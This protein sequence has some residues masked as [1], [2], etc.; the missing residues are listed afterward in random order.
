[1]RV[2]FGAA[3]AQAI[4]QYRDEVGPFRSAEEP[5]EVKGLWAEYRETQQDAHPSKNAQELAHS[6]CLSVIMDDDRHQFSGGKLERNLEP[7]V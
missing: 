6:R 4:I 3:K 2:G 5:E 7:N 1:M